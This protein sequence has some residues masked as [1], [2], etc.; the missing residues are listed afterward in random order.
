MDGWVEYN[1]RWTYRDS[2]GTPTNQWKKINEA[3]YMFDEN[4]YALSDQWVHYKEK[5]YWLKSDCAMALGWH[6]IDGK[7]YFFDNDGS[8][9]E[10]WLKYYDKWYYLTANNGDMISRECRNINGD[11]YYFNEDGD[12][13]EK[14]NIIVD[15]NGK[16]QF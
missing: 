3:W 12:M 14:A 6:K 1:N 13:L 8:M 11:W 10:G 5:W 9:H 4:G 2:D 15:E 7:W 16:I